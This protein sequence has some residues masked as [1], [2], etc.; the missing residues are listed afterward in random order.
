LRKIKGLTFIEIII[1]LVIIAALIS[2][3]ALASRR[4]IKRAILTEAACVLRYLRLM[5]ES[6]YAQ[7]GSYA[8]TKLKTGLFFEGVDPEQVDGRYFSK[9]AYCTFEFGTRFVVLCSINQN[10]SARSEYV[11]DVVGKG[12]LIIMSWKGAIYVWQIP[13]SGFMDI[14]AGGFPP[15]PELLEST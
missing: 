6:Y 5:Q 10:T 3:V 7:H 4:F 13:N 15:P 12:G 11:T 2:I 1:S 9:E 8:N 14:T